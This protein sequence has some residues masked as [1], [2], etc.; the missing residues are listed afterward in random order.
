MLEQGALCF[1]AEN[2]SCIE[3]QSPD[4]LT[5]PAESVES[6]GRTII[7]VASEEGDASMDVDLT[8]KS[9]FIRPNKK[10]EGPSQERTLRARIGCSLYH[11]AAEE[12]DPTPLYD[13]H[14]FSE[15]ASG[16]NVSQSHD[17]GGMKAPK[18]AAPLSLAEQYTMWRLRDRQVF[19]YLVL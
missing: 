12:M 14:T 19:N 1:E 7:S 9:Q 11:L 8:A 18:T 10:Y 16:S 13:A 6:R 15:C 17:E 3:I 5:S 4:H 2:R